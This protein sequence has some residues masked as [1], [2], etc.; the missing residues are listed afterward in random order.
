VGDQLPR[1][2]PILSG[3]KG[4]ER[5]TLKLPSQVISELVPGAAVAVL[6]GP[7]HAEEV[8][9]GLPTTVVAA[10]EDPALAAAA[11]LTLNS[12]R[13]RV[14][15]SRD[16]I[17]VE[18]GGAAKNVIALAAG[19]ADGLG[20]GDNARSG[21]VTRGLHEITRLG[22]ALG[23]EPRT[24]A[25]LSGMG[26]LVATCTSGHSRNR[27]VGSRIARGESLEAILASTAMVAE[28]VETT[29]SMHGLAARLGVHLPITAEVYS[30][31]FE[32]KAARDAVES[33]MARDLKDERA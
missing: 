17:G 32:G 15:T 6:S 8:S 11:Q 2:V 24:F 31:L 4:F 20:S 5:G 30:V 18:V 7:S 25:G 9:R 23:A 22:V 26:D 19:I 28:G 33:L 1:A 13:F 3:S 27:A 16:V 14:Y 29:R 10:A 12:P 21:L